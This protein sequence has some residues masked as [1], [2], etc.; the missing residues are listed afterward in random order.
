MTYAQVDAAI[1]ENKVSMDIAAKILSKYYCNR[2]KMK[3]IKIDG[4]KFESLPNF[5]FEY[6][7]L[8]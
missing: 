1:R 6:D 7:F 3:M 8:V 5:I 2:F 4:P